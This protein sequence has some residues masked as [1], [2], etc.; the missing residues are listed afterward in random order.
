MD[1]RATEL[2]VR[3]EVW[4]IDL[5]PVRGHELAGRRPA[6][7]VSNDHFNRG[8]AGKMIVVP[9]TTRR[10]GVPFDVE[11]RPPE[12]DAWEVSFAKCEDV[13]SVSRER[14]VSP[15]GTVTAG[16][17]D[18]IGDRLRILLDL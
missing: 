11:V 14:L 3:G 6:I 13:R 9:L 18:L 5:D 4:L 10:R 1:W 16:A 12:G 8:P 17:L 2:A 15:W 7:I